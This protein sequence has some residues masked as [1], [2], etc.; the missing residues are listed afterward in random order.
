MRKYS[1]FSIS[2]IFLNLIIHHNNR[3]P[4]KKRCFISVLNSLILVPTTKKFLLFTIVILELEN[5]E[6][7]VY[8]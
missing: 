4:Q 7:N 5:L 2:F 1:A 8:R 3:T 6:K